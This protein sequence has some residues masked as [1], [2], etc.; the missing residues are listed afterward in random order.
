MVSE[1]SRANRREPES[2][3]AMSAQ[4]IIE[5]KVESP[6]TSRK[7]E[8]EAGGEA[9]WEDVGVL[10]EGEEAEVIE[11]KDDVGVLPESEEVEVIETKAEPVPEAKASPVL[12]TDATVEK[13]DVIEAAQLA[14]A[15]SDGDVVV[16]ADVI[17]DSGVGLET[18]GETDSGS[19]EGWMQAMMKQIQTLADE[20]M[21]QVDEK[22]KQADEK[23][24]YNRD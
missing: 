7:G 18:A 24:R 4:D 17:G 21:K 5:E 6:D 12:E 13:L 22:M 3:L 15:G 11:A 1:F 23:V 19:M 8:V 9:E 20:K 2:Q 16:A 14:R 10:P